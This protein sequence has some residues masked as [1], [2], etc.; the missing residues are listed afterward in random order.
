MVP[1][2]PMLSAAFWTRLI[3]TCLIC[4]PSA[5]IQFGPDEFELKRDAGL[6]QLA[7]EEGVHLFQEALGWQANGLRVGRPGELEKIFDDLFETVDLGADDG[8]V[9]VVGKLRWERFSQAEEPELER[10]EGIADFVGDASGESA[11]RGELF[12]ALDDGLTLGENAAKRGDH[13]AISHH[14]QSDG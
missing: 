8:G 2:R 7:G 11:E 4:W 14:G 5:R 6:F 9:F 3:S 13:A 10:G 12:L 1:L